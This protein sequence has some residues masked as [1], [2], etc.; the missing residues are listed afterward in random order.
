MALGEG[1]LMR[2]RWNLGDGFLESFLAGF[3]FAFTNGLRF[4]WLL[5]STL[6]AV[7]VL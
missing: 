6:C 5:V 4:T 2:L 1:V 3:L 7:G